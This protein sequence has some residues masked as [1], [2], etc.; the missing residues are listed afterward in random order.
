MS[1]P[2]TSGP[3]PFS[4]GEADDVR[5][6]WQQLGL[7]GLI[8]VHTHFMPRSVM[9]KVWAYFDSVGPLVGREWPITY[10]ADEETRIEAL[11]AFGIRAFSSLVYP[12]KP[13]MAE[14]LNGW[15]ADFA[16]RHPDCLRTA[17]FYPEEQART[18]VSRAIA[19][20]VQ[21]FKCHVQVGD[22]SPLDS[23]LDGVWSQIADT[24]VPVIIHC[25]SG[26]A[27]GRFTGPAPIEKL[28]QRFPSLPLI[29]AHMG[30][31]EYA[32]FLDLAARFE[33]V[34]LDTTMSF[35]D[36]S[37]EGAP[38]P[39]ELV[40]RLSDLRAKILFG[41]DFP[42]IP[43]GYTHALDAVIRLDLGDDWLRAVLHDNA[44]RL[45]GIPPSAG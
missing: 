15:A 30:T 1:E 18:Y 2:T 16:S 44:A 37:E 12:H 26:P 40:P 11:R 24:G 38:Y 19:S 29:V 14:W 28:L 13:D 17:T 22:F 45:F 35:T 42:N 34:R 27:P 33:N 6:V 3:A 23:L 10:R 39:A 5:R 8:D 41:S 32:E 20:G 36:F 31:P 25:G 4:T 7:P 9:D 43:Y 21:V